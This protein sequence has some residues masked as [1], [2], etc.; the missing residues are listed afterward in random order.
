MSNRE[1]LK[2]L[3]EHYEKRGVPFAFVLDTEDKE[4]WLIV[5]FKFYEMVPTLR[6]NYHLTMQTRLKPSKDFHWE[7]KDEFSEIEG[8]LDHLLEYQASPDHYRAIH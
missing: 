4:T 5:E 7:R 6:W 2:S 3:V 8:L 1:E